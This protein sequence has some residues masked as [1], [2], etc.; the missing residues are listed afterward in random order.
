VTLYRG[1]GTTQQILG[2]SP[3]DY[4]GHNVASAGDYDGDGY[5]DVLVSTR[6][7][8]LPEADE[9][10]L[11]L[12]RGGPNGLDSTPAWTLETSVANSQLGTISGTIGGDFDDDGVQDIVVGAHGFA[13]GE[14]SE[15]RAMVFSGTNPPP[16]VPFW[17]FDSDQVNAIYGLAIVSAD[18]N[19]DGD[20]DI[21]SGAYLWDD[22]ADVTNR[23]DL[24]RIDVFLGNGSSLPSTPSSTSW[25]L[26]ADALLGVSI[27]TLDVNLDGRD[28]V[29]AGAWQENHPSFGDSGA[30]HLWLGTSNG[31]AATPD[32]SWR[33]QELSAYAGIRVAR[34][35]DVNGDGYPDALVGAS[36]HDS[37]NGAD[38]GRA[39]LFLGG[40]PRSGP[41]V[42]AGTLVFTTGG[43]AT[44]SGASF[45]DENPVATSHRCEWDWGDG[46]AVQQIDPCVDPSLA[47]HVYSTGTFAPRLR[48]I[49]NDGRAG[50]AIGVAVL[51]TSAT[52]AALLRAPPG[53]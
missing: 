42:R 27:S 50:E 15:G 10:A 8:D 53:R 22:P 6:Y 28:D 19:G 51:T 9:G 46:S 3:N 7:A 1:N 38:S 18:V 5:G 13:S 48:V 2:F 21:V 44:A 14:L 34:A 30:A 35:G 16:A 26:E 29:L 33:A 36:G 52:P 25:G 47:T 12:L 23:F 32:W 24:G 17:S 40:L 4:F 37:P 43:L 20:S 41:R 31:I 11:H 45:L 49:A 39:F